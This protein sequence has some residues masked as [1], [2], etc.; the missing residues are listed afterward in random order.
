MSLG[1]FKCQKCGKTSLAFDGETHR[2][3]KGHAF[4]RLPNTPGVVHATNT[5]M[6]DPLLD[7]FESSHEAQRL[8]DLEAAYERETIAYNEFIKN[9]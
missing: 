3:P 6:S 1:I 9:I 7:S 2:L 4:E 5:L 8:L